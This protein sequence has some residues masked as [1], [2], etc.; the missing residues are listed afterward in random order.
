MPFDVQGANA[1]GYSDAEI[2]DHLAATNNF[3]AAAARQSGYTDPEV[4][5]HLADASPPQTTALG[6]ARN[7]AAGAVDVGANVINTASDPFTNLIGRPLAIAGTTAY[8][9]IA[10]IFGGDRLSPELTSTIVGND[11][12]PQPGTALMTGIGNLTGASPNDV[13]ANTP[14]ERITRKVVGA[15][16]S[17]AALG[18]AGLTAPI[19]GAS[20]AIAG[21][22]LAAIAP[23]WAKQGAEL[24][25]NVI[26]GYAGAKVAKVGGSAANLASGT[27]SPTLA[28]YRRLG[29]D[30]DLTG[31]VTGSPGAQF[32]QAYSS[33]SLG[34]A[35]VISPLERKAVGQFN[36]A[37]EQ[38][39]Q[40]LGGARDAQAAGTALQAEARNWQDNVFPARQAAAWA[41]VDQAMAN[42]AVDPSN[43]RTALGA[44]S[45]K[46]SALPETQKALLP[47]RAAQ[48]LDAINTDVPAGSTMPWNQAQQLRSAIGEIMGVPEV[49]QS[50]GTQALSRMYGGL[51]EDMKT[52]AQA[53]NAGDLFDNA[54]AVTT[55]GHAFIDNTLSKIIRSNNPA[56]ETVRPEQATAHVLGGGDTTLEGLRAEMPQAAN[57]LAAYKL[58]DMAMATPGNAGRT[59][60]DT[61]VGTFLTDLN[62]MRQSSP[63]GTKALFSDPA[64][65]QRVDD[66]ATAADAMKETAKRANASGTAS[67][68]I[69]PQMALAA[70]ET[71][72]ATGSVPLTVGAVAAPYIAN[73][74]AALSVSRP[75]ITRFASTPS[76]TPRSGA[77]GLIGYNALAAPPAQSRLTGPPI[78][79]LT[80]LLGPGPVSA[81]PNFL[82]QP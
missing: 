63:N 53:N 16:G 65:T 48:M 8:N 54:N 11:N 3:D 31:D 26:G 60:T 76:G 15:A 7:V 82:A 69:I 24:A 43:Y 9:T 6:L 38:T 56:Q 13:P 71:Y 37:V 67:H 78:N 52:S 61:S 62:R 79:P 50:L 23:D 27:L 40:T 28:A 33:K 72:H 39:A 25:G 59:G 51:S 41:P 44:L 1:A 36:D 80:T 75:W 10:P 4:I 34:G 49:S 12:P 74:A 19:V 2:A 22:Q 42:A 35:S 21:D 64:I 18:P 14:L 17:A 66:L 68:M 47:P 57:E 5:A 29:I 77:L 20:G 46:L 70:G 30:T 32:L 58:R 55:A 45:S 81:P 73:K